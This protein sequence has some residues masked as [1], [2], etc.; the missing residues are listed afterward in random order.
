MRCEQFHSLKTVDNGKAILRKRVADG[1]IDERERQLIMEFL[2]ERMAIAK[3]F[4]GAKYVG[5]CSTIT[6][7]RRAQ[8]ITVPYYQLTKADLHQ[9]IADYKRLPVRKFHSSGRLEILDK[10]YAQNTLSTNLKELK[11]WLLWLAENNIIEIPVSEIRKIEPPVY[12]PKKIDAESVYSEPMIAE[13]VEPAPVMVK[14]LIWSHYETGARGNEIC[15]LRWGDI[16]WRSKSALITIRD[17]KEDQLRKALISMHSVQHLL[18]WRNMYPGDPRGEAHVFLNS[19]NKNLTYPSIEKIYHN[20]QFETKGKKKIRRMPKFT[21]HDVRRWRTTN[22]YRQNV[23]RSTVC[24]MLWG[25]TKT[26]C[27]SGYS[28]FSTGD[29]HSELEVL[30]GISE[31]RDTQ[32]PLQPNYCPACGTLNAAGIRFCGSCGRCLS[33]DA[34]DQLSSVEL[35]IRQSPEYLAALQEYIREEVKKEVD[36][37]RTSTGRL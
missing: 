3:R 11:L 5:Y 9:A 1:S 19:E 26:K 33:D 21:V 14:A 4:G 18:A 12:Q 30:Y 37:R 32:K 8:Y 28:Q 36:I 23:S 35:S 24:K 20:L 6:H 7:L 31:I 27:D 17:T 22:L 29:M 34:A 10:T 15:D 13:L 16:E 25:S 2:A